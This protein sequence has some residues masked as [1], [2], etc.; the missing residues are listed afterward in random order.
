[1]GLSKLLGRL[2]IALFL[3]IGWVSFSFGQVITV[4]GSQNPLVIVPSGTAVS[5]S[6]YV[7]WKSKYVPSHIIFQFSPIGT[8]VS[9]NPKV[10][11]TLDD[12]SLTPTDGTKWFNIAI[13]AP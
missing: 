1:M 4:D 13:T 12:A 3:I 2:F 6:T 7:A 10:Y 9:I 11:C 8:P 5:T